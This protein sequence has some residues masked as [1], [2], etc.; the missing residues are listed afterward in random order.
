VGLDARHFRVP[1]VKLPQL[2]MAGFFPNN[3]VADDDNPVS[4]ITYW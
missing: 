1:A 3:S 4:N 2:T